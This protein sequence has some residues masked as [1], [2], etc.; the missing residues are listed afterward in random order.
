MSLQDEKRLAR[1]AATAQRK[2]ASLE[3]GPEAANRLAENLL[4]AVPL[5][6]AAAVSGFLPI[7]SEIDTRP[8]LNR[9][10]EQEREICL[11]VV[12]GKDRPLVFRRW[13]DGDPMVEEA[14]GTQ[15]PAPEAPEIEPDLLLVPLLAF[16]RAGYRLGYGGGF[17]DRTLA[18]L[19]VLK[20]VLAVGVAFAG[21]EMAYV[22]R[23][24]LDQPLDWIVTER[25]AI[26][27]RAVG[28]P[29]LRLV[30]PT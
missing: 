6:D 25:E 10:L 3:A 12:L 7:G 1:K 17:Y 9:F 20:P 13:R 30:D 29:D 26:R 14:F 2:S 23:D 22:P 21:Q 28:K 18:R 4:A 16:D 24:D 27:I 5:R 15:A 8:L 11:P 19:R